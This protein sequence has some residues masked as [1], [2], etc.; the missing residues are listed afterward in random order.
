MRH[1]LTPVIGYT[2]SGNPIHLI[3][4]GSEPAVEQP[5]EAP[6]SSQG[7]SSGTTEAV[8]PQQTETPWSKYLEGVPS[9]F[10]PVISERFKEWDADTTRKFQQVHSEYEPL[11]A[12]QPL[13]QAG[14]DPDQ[15]LSLAETIN[16][17]PRRLYDAL[18][19]QFGDEW[20]I[21]NGQIVTP[22]QGQQG[23]VDDEELE[24]DPRYAE[25]KSTVDILADIFLEQHRREQAQTED[26]QLDA[27]LGALREKHGDYD[28][29]V[30][31]GLMNAGLSGEDAV[32]AY[33]QSIQSALQANNRPTA[34]RIL[35][36][37]GGV[38]VDSVDLSK[39]QT[40]KD[41][42]AQMLANSKGA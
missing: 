38:P 31:L 19:S 4:G 24:T 27:Y 28:E 34:P 35:G 41:V 37:G 9:A 13:A 26:Q 5:V 15:L 12:Y 32:Q 22:E 33:Q 36:S 20:G 14:Y 11:K 10:V 21:S 2:K 7:Q 8:E 18:V 39:P 23:T 40:R 42:I 30:V 29:R 3:M 25:L 6:D 1:P 17:D 16:T